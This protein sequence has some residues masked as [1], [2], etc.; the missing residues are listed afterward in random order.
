MNT[1]NDYL[2]V[3]AEESCISLNKVNKYY[4]SI[5]DIP[6]IN[7]DDKMHS[8]NC[9]CLLI[10]LMKNKNNQSFNYILSDAL[11]K[12]YR[13]DALPYITDEYEMQLKKKNY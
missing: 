2:S 6:C 1:N 7:Q 13:E 9:L 5:K 11:Y 8:L 10:S 4:D 12:T 3:I